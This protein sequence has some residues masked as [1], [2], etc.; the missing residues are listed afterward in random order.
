MSETLDPHRIEALR[1]ELK[2]PK[3]VGRWSEETD[4]IVELVAQERFADAKA[5]LVALEESVDRVFKADPR[6]DPTARNI[7]NIQLVTTQIGR[8]KEHI[9]KLEADSMP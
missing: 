2:I 5:K 9:A 7:D 1:H 8:L 6:T 4:G 3:F